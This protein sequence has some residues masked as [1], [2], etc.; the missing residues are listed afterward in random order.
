[1]SETFKE[2]PPRPAWAD[3]N[4]STPF[5]NAPEGTEDPDWEV[6][7]HFLREVTVDGAT[8]RIEEY[9]TRQEGEEGA[10]LI[11]RIGP[12]VSFS[13]DDMTPEMARGA[14]AALAR[15]LDDYDASV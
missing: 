11:E 1:M 2:W 4:Q 14:Q 15:L 8:A 5:A 3:Q 6:E 9:H 10:G 7:R 13:P 12:F